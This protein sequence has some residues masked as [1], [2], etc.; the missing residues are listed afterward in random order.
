MMGLATTIAASADGISSGTPPEKYEVDCRNSDGSVSASVSQTVGGALTGHFRSPQGSIPNVRVAKQAPSG[1]GTPVEKPLL[2]TGKN[3]FIQI[4][5][6]DLPVQ[7]DQPLVRVGAFKARMNGR[8]WSG[9]L[10][11]TI[12]P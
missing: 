4:F 2:Y 11:C 5:I 7:P 10:P 3:F 1:M 9:N 12:Y 8:L 6:T